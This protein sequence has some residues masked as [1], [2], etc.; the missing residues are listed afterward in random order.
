MNKIGKS[1]V[2]LTLAAVLMAPRPSAA[3][4][5]LAVGTSGDVAADGIAIGDAINEA[6]PE[7]AAASALAYCR[8][9]NNHKTAPNAVP[10]CQI[11]GAF[12]RQC[13][14]YA[15]DPANKT[16]GAGWAIAAT[17][18]AAES[19]A[20]A[21]CQTAAGASRSQFCKVIASRCDKKDTG[22]WPY[23]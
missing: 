5:A 22:H 10:H 19:Q 13:D 1:F 12:R 23:K 20:L 8:G 7:E 14:A 4:G 2:L 18:D 16:P 17:K 6:T 9:K 15:L 11:V 21:N 3:E